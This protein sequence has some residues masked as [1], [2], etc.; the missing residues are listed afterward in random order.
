MRQVALALCLVAMPLSAAPEKWWDSYNRGV[1]AVNA[2][3]YAEAIPALQKALAEMPTE[4]TAVRAKNQI[5]TYVPHFW[6]GIAK[7]NSGDVD[8]ALREW[9]TS[10]DQGAI[11]RTEYYPKLRDWVARA[12]TEKV[13]NARAAAADSKKAAD[14][15]LNQ[16]LSGQ[17]QALSDGGDRSESYRA[18]Q[19][20]LQ[21]AL[22]VFNSAGSDIRAY[23]NAAEIAG[24]ARDLFARAADDAKKRRLARPAASKPAIKA[25][26]ITPSPV[27][28]DAPPLVA[29][30]LVAT[31]PPAAAETVVAEAVMAE[32]V[33]PQLTEPTVETLSATRSLTEIITDPKVSVRS[34]LESAYRAYAS[35]RFEV[36]ERALTSI[37]DTS[38]SGE[39][40]L[41][42]GCTRYTRAMLSRDSGALLSEARS[43]FEAALK[44]NRRLR[45][46]QRAF[47]PKLIAFFDEVKA[48]L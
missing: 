4:S 3:N 40:Y 46:D 17:A 7:F 42:R 44:I 35:G 23:N 48:G 32:T 11:S 8:G 29:T 12:Q 41:L 28:V 15:A 31:P 18:A 24:Q 37:L 25:A 13:R 22:G 10:E 6:L 38:A 45:L 26:Q 16:A 19:R 43:D 1:K 47:S 30:P 20:K 2:S 21:E 33:R 5:I 14:S 36:S 9:K 27:I 39:A 34:Q